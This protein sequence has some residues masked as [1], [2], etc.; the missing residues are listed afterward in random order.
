MSNTQSNSF[1]PT[2]SK[3]GLT[4]NVEGGSFYY[5]GVL[6]IVTAT[7]ISLTK[8]TTN[9][10]VLTPSTGVISANTSGFT[11]ILFPIAVIKT[12]V[13]VITS[14]VDSRPDYLINTASGSVITVASGQQALNT[15]QIASG[16]ASVIITTTA[17][18]VLTTDNLIADFDADPTGVTGYAPSANG[19]LTIVKFCTSG[20]VNFY[21][22]NNTASPITPGAITLN[23]RVLR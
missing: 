18:G 12:N 19:M 8:N 9:Y 13:N 2:I 11:S 4:V 7:N 22:I 17:T 21:A 10:I 6:S 14:L 5:N 3:V 16:A 20:N 1:A 15:A 23:W